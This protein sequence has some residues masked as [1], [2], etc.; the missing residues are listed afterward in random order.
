MAS[1]NLVPPLVRALEHV[2]LEPRATHDVAHLVRFQEARKDRMHLFQIVD[3]AY[4]HVLNE[5]NFFALFLYKGDTAVGCAG[6]RLKWI[7]TTL[8]EE[9]TSLRFYYDDVPRMARERERCI[10]TAPTARLIEACP[11]VVSLSVCV[12]HDHAKGNAVQPLMR[13]LHLWA[14]VHW[15]WS[16]LIGIAER[17]VSRVYTYD[18][19]GFAGAELGLW[20]NRPSDGYQP[21]GE[22][23]LT[24]FMFLSAPRRHTMATFLRADVADVGRPLGLPMSAMVE[25]AAA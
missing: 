23:P 15:R 6:L 4:Q 7:E 10:V 3:P 18:I 21:D 20:R 1:R 22:L 9:L 14:A 13:L 5:T 11:V 8:A 24:E 16:W 25:D 19:Y 17:R 2:D 12:D